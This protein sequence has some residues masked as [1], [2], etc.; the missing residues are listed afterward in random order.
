MLAKEPVNLGL[1]LK[2]CSAVRGALDRVQVQSTNKQLQQDSYLVMYSCM[3][4][5]LL[6]M[7]CGLSMPGS[8]SPMLLMLLQQSTW[9]LGHLTQKG[10]L[11]DGI[12]CDTGSPV[13]AR[14]DH[15]P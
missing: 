7:S 11:C 15:R 14:A 13:L 8:H 5:E 12:W 9:W 2:I 1:C 4:T 6:N 10:L 3:L